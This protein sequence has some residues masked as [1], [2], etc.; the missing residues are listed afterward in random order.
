MPNRLLVIAFAVL[1]TSGCASSVTGRPVAGSAP[2][3]TPG[4]STSSASATSKAPQTSAA[5]ATTCEFTQATDGGNVTE[6]AP[7]A[8]T[9]VATGGTPTVT[10]V[11][12]KGP[13]KIELDPAAG[14][15]S[16]HNL[17]HLVAKKFYDGTKCHR[18][19]TSP[20]LSVLQCGDPSFTGAGTPGYEFDDKMPAEGVYQRGIVAMANAGPGTNGCQ[21]FIVYGAAQIGPDYP[22]LGKV[23]SGMEIVD[24]V[25]AAGVE[26]GGDDGTPTQPLV[27]TSASEG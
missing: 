20:S 25:A 17:R 11:T 2:T 12:D 4:S 6:V 27:L 3:T 24:K 13:L 23:V 14:P 8:G 16:V 10:F 1:L 18:L 7:P 22:V 21:F 9:D 15:C 5:P 19:T 26:G